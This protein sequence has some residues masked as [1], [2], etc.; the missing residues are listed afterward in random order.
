MV[1]GWLIEEIVDETATNQEKKILRVDK[2]K[3][4]FQHKVVS[5]KSKGSATFKYGAKQHISIVENP[6]RR[7]KT[8][9]QS[10]QKQSPI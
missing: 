2:S 3:T 1:A 4:K 10:Q 5:Y 8:N 7:T 9:P 6:I